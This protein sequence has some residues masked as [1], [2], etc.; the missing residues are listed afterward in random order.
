MEKLFSLFFNF[1]LGLFVTSKRFNSST[2]PTRKTGGGAGA[3]VKERAQLSAPRTALRRRT[4]ADAQRDGRYETHHWFLLL[5]DFLSLPVCSLT[6]RGNSEKGCSEC[7]SL[8]CHC[9]NEL[10]TM[11]ISPQCAWISHLGFYNCNT[12]HCVHSPQPNSPHTRRY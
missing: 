12:G 3:R 2:T 11:N 4:T 10:G 8:R 1:T 6:L 9:L 5:C 7:R